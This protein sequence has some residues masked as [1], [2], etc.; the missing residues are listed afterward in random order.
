M[1][2]LG[3][4]KWIIGTMSYFVKQFQDNETLYNQARTFWSTLESYSIFIVI[5]FIL[6]GMAIAWGYYKPLSR[7]CQGVLE[8]FR[9]KIL[10]G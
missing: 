5:L 1:K 2:L 8:I 3:L 4:Y 9:G 10:V 7:I 6:G